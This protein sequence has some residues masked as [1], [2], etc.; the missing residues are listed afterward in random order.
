MI[1]HVVYKQLKYYILHISTTNKVASSC[2]DNADR[3]H[4]IDEKNNLQEGEETAIHRVEAKA[5]W[6]K[7]QLTRY[8]AKV[9]KAS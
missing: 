2:V 6:T 3:T 8:P 1:I 9:F 5:L 7:P 4:T